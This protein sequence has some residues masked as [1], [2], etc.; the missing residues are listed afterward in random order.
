MKVEELVFDAYYWAKFS[1][2][3]E[4]IVV[5]HYDDGFGGAIEIHGSEEIFGLED[6]DFLKRIEPYE[7]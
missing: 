7:S 5:H 2:T 4:P 1:G 6:F 3:Q